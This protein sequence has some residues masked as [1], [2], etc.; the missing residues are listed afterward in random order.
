MCG[1]PA[2][3]P[4]A[5]LM[6]Q[7]RGHTTTPPRSPS[8]TPLSIL[9]RMLQ[10]IRTHAAKCCNR[11]LNRLCITHTPSVLFPGLLEQRRQSLGLSLAVL[12]VVRGR[13]QASP[14][15]IK[16]SLPASSKKN[17]T[18]AQQGAIGQRTNATKRHPSINRSDPETMK[19]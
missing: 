16:L 1:V 14:Y 11:S 6:A 5:P 9:N 13:P 7:F 12:R 17:R 8:S 15:A 18:S 19:E 3:I 2:C 10:Q 4:A